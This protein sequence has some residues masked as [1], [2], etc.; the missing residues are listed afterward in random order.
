MKCILK[1]A[2]GICIIALLN[3]SAQ[4]TTPWWNGLI[5]TPAKH[6]LQT[7]V[8]WAKKHPTAATVAA[9]SAGITTLSI[10]AYA[11][12]RWHSQPTTPLPLHKIEF[13][14]SY[15]QPEFIVKNMSEALNLNSNN[16][17]ITINENF[18]K[19]QCSDIAIKKKILEWTSSHN[20]DLKR[21]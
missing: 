21:Q 17:S 14:C 4:A 16:T 8:V 20:F 1:K 3:I 12:Y 18:I 11:Q 2:L 9:L 5:T 13:S 6:L 19:V 7:T 15:Y 10:L